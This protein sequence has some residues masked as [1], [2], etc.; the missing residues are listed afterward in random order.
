M[1]A[2]IAFY[3]P[4]YYWLSLSHPPAALGTPSVGLGLVS[5]HQ[6]GLLTPWETARNLPVFAE[7]MP[8]EI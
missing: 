7:E 2:R 1:P 6:V 3:L 5:R 4:P 8:I